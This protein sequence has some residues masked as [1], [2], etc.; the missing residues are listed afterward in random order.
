MKNLSRRTL[1]KGAAASAAAWNFQVV[2]S[3]VFGANSKPT[4]GAIG[5][6]GKG[7]ADTKGCDEAGFQVVSLGPDQ[8]YVTF[9]G[10]GR[11][12]AIQRAFDGGEVVQVEVREFLFDD[13]AQWQT[14]LQHVERVRRS[15]GILPPRDETE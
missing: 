5:T 15:N 4:L 3:R 6:G 9:E 8:G 2:P 7:A 12:F 1:V 11:A 14:V 10:N 13:E